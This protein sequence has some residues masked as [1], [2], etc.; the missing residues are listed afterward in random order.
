MDGAV[1]PAADAWAICVYQ[2]CT[3]A[4]TNN[5]NLKIQ[6]DKSIVLKYLPAFTAGLASQTQRNGRYHHSCGDVAIHVYG[7]IYYI[8]TSSV[9]L[10]SFL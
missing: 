6:S 9:V 2:S 8:I 10:T 1:L 3:H 4:S 5:R 7:G